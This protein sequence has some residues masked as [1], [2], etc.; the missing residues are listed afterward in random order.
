M[1]ASAPRVACR[2]PTPLLMRVPL[3]IPPP[4]VDAVLM[5]ATVSLSARLLVSV[6]GC[7]GSGE[8]HRAQPGQ[9]VHLPD[10]DDHPRPPVR[11]HNRRGTLNH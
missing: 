8:V 7:L 2:V 11:I 9:G 6:D 1:F 5:H 3:Y 4:R 10:G